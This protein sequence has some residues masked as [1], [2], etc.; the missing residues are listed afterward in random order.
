MHPALSLLLWGLAVIGVQLQTGWLLAGLTTGLLGLSAGL[1]GARLARLLRRSRFLM[2]AI[3]VLFAGFTPGQ[4]VWLA[5]AWLPLTEEGTVLAAIHLAR[6]ASVVALVAILLER[7]PRADLVLAISVLVSPVRWLGG[8]PRRFA[9]RLA[10][11][12]DLVAE[13]SASDWRSWL[14]APAPGEVPGSIPWRQRAFGW[15]DG[16]VLAGILISVILWQI[17]SA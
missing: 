7:L 9:V 16:A 3:L 2:L 14:D 5:P 6:L 12:L 8:D 17:V 4:R 13:R 15:L 1:A 11:V 10:L